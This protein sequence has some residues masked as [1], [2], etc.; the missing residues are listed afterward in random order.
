MA[1]KFS[2]TSAAARLAR[3]GTDVAAHGCRRPVAPGLPCAGSLKLQN[4]HHTHHP[5]PSCKVVKARHKASGRIV[6]LKRVWQSGG[7]FGDGGGDLGDLP[8]ALLR[9][10]HALQAVRHANVVQLHRTFRLVR[11][12]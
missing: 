9:E 3:C 7:C 11:H 1:T 10:V 4:C 6:A 12:L 5:R 8:P 2:S